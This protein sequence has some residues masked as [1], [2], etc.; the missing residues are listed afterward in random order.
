MVVVQLFDDP[1]HPYPQML[2]DAAP[3]MDGFGR[4][5]PPPQGEIPDPIAPPPGCAFAGRCTRASNICRSTVPELTSMGD[6]QLA[7]CHHPL[8]D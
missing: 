8:D 3:K 4:E 2:L 5:V 7:A 6:D 1:K